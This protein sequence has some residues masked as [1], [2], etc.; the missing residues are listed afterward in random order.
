MGEPVLA[1]HL[2][3]QLVIDEVDLTLMNT[4]MPTTAHHPAR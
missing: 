2:A 3:E 1:A 4:L